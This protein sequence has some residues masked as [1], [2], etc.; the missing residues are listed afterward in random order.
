[1]VTGVQTCALPIS[2]NVDLPHQGS[3]TSLRFT[4]QAKLVSASRDGTLRI[5][6]LH[7]KGVKLERMEEGRLGAVGQLDVDRD[8][9]YMLFD[10]LGKELQILSVQTGRYICSLQNPFGA[11]PFETLAL[12]SPDGS[13]LLTA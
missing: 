2:H 7:Q 1:H 12:F 6:G 10:K 3:V 8:G 9:K 5:W 11:M 13:L 4:P